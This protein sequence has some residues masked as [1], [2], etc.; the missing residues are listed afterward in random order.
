[1][2]YGTIWTVGS[3]PSRHHGK[4]SDHAIQGHRRGTRIVPPLRIATPTRDAE[5]GQPGNNVLCI[6]WVRRAWLKEKSVL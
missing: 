2:R 4:R 5:T 3:R 6:A 1:M